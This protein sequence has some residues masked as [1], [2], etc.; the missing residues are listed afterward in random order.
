VITYEHQREMPQIKSIN[1]QMGVW[2]LPELKSQQADDVL[3]YKDNSI[4]EFPRSNVFMVS[5]GNTLVTPKNNILAGIT[6]KNILKLAAGIIPVE[7]R[8][9][10]V[11]EIIQAR[12]LMCCS[13][14]KRIVP[15][16]KVNGRIIGDGKPGKFTR[17]LYE[18]LL[19][20]ENALVSLTNN[21]AG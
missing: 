7:E 21:A 16:L 5:A 19:N 13:T 17:A 2:L 15:V 1:Y 4:T 14:R 12:E 11:E 8:D 10:Q 3:Y 9:I 6:R 18:R 20:H